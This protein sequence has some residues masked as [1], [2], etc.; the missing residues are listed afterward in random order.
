M[1]RGGGGLQR[2]EGTTGLAENAGFVGIVIVTQRFPHLPVAAPSAFSH[3]PR[4]SRSEPHAAP[5]ALGAVHISFTHR[6]PAAH[7]SLEQACPTAGSAASVH[8]PPRQ[9][10]CS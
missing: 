10:R 4:H 6:A 8:F 9:A 2:G 5:S 3:A 1:P 7:L